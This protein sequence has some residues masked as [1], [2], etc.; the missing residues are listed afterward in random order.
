MSNILNIRNPETGLFEPI[1]TLKGEKGEPGLDGVQ[2]DDD[3]VSTDTTWSSEKVSGQLNQLSEEI[4][5]L[6]G[7]AKKD[8]VTYT[9]TLD[10]YLKKDGTVVTTTSYAYHTDYIPLDGYA[11]IVAKAKITTNGWALAFFNSERVLDSSVSVAGNGASTQTN[12][13]MAVPAGV[14]YCVLSHYAGENNVNPG[15]ITLYPA[16]TDDPLFGKTINVL[17]DSITSTMYVR[18]TWWEMIAEKTGAEFNNHGVSGTSIAVREGRTDSFVERAANMETDADAVIV[19][20]GTNDTATPRGAWGS[21]ENTTFFGVLNNLIVLL[22]DMFQGKPVIICTPIQTAVDYSSNVYNPVETLMGKNDTDTLT[23]QERAAAIKLKCEQ[24]GMHC[25][26]LYNS[27]G[28]GGADNGNVYYRDGDTLHP[29]ESGQKRLANLMRREL[30][31]FF[32][33]E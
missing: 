30:E 10:G 3:T 5:E 23:M 13:D 8:P 26:D 33:I 11:R 20:G 16:E 21:K 4:E 29:S 22:C 32:G 17:G 31:R 25:L 12:I 15:Y 18:P 19:M 27:S 6:K 28:I 7:E 24:H 1:L 2:I 9:A 14:A